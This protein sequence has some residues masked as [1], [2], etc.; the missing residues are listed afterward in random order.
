M[1]ACGVGYLSPILPLFLQSSLSAPLLCPPSLSLSPFPPPPSLS[2]SFSQS[3][4]LSLSLL[5]HSLL[6][7][8]RLPFSPSHSFLSVPSPP[9]IA[10]HVLQG[11]GPG[12]LLSRPPL[13]HTSSNIHNTA[14]TIAARD[15]TVL[16]TT[17]YSSVACRM[18][19]I[20]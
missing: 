2:S 13:K 16:W 14:H 20:L 7:P 18:Y 12:S 3:L 6:S 17:N 4:T 15:P 9:P 11:E 19:N 1:L 8:P 10:L 5:S